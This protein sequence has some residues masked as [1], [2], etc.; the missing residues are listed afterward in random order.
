M[1]DEIAYA[2]SNGALLVRIRPVDPEN[3]VGFN[4]LNKFRDLSRSEKSLKITKSQT[5]G[6]IVYADYRDPLLV[7]I[8][9]VDHENQ[10][11]WSLAVF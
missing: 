9:Q 1:A 5:T 6:E 3:K 8:R 2:D 10:V 7:R 11:G 4:R